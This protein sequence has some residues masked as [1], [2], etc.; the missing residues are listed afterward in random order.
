MI[1]LCS[2]LG[3]LKT[4]TVA[5]TDEKRTMKPLFR[6]LNSTVI[7]SNFNLKK[8]EEEENNYKNKTWY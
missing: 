3:Q 2:N 1:N 4:K 7:S 5:I 6:S 8:E